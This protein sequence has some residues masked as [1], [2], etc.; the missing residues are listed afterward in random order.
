MDKIG[1]FVWRKCNGNKSV[2][3]ILEILKKE[4]PKEKNIDQR[5][6][7]F[8]QQMGVLKYIIY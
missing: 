3:E 2:G 1:S 8:I 5:L 4:F 6:F 7:L